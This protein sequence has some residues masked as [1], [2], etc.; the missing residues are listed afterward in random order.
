[1]FCK[2]ICTISDDFSLCHLH[3]YTFFG[4]FA[5][6]LVIF[7]GL[8]LLDSVIVCTCCLAFIVYMPIVHSHDE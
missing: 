7:G 5:H 6:I 4:I 3:C 2:F 1:M 8:S